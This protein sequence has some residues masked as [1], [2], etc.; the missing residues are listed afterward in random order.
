MGTLMRALHFLNGIPQYGGGGG[1][2]AGLL[3]AGRSSPVPVILQGEEGRLL[4]LARRPVLGRGWPIC[5]GWPRLQQAAVVSGQIHAGVAA[6]GCLAAGS[7]GPAARSESPAAEAMWR[8][9]G[10]GEGW[11]LAGWA[12]RA[13]TPTSLAPFSSPLSSFSLAAALFGSLLAGSGEEL[14]AALLSA[15]WWLLLPVVLPRGDGCQRAAPHGGSP[16][17]GGQPLWLSVFRLYDGLGASSCGCTRCEDA[18]ST[19]S[20]VGCRRGR[21]QSSLASFFVSASF[22]VAF[23]RQ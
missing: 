8:A 17:S 9:V 23:S 1:N 15:G 18:R 6:S 3:A 13:S 22:A 10:C 14:R 7:V 21:P 11:V 16:A 12:A 20:G 19:C 4:Q 2:V 5:G